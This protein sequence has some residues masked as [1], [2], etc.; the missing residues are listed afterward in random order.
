MASAD[1]SAEASANRSI[2]RGPRGVQFQCRDRKLDFLAKVATKIAQIAI[3][4]LTQTQPKV[5]QIQQEMLYN[6][7]V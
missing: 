7:Q 4:R 6:L 1:A 3:C 5:T 2:G